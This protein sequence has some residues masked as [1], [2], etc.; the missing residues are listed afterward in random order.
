MR[1]MCEACRVKGGCANDEAHS[2]FVCILFIIIS[3]TLGS[4][5][6]ACYRDK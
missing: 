4:L 2:E 5:D 1:H 6:I 3:Q